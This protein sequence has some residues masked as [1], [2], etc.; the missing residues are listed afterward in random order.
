MWGGPRFLRTQC[1]SGFWFGLKRRG[2]P[3]ANPGERRCCF[4]RGGRLNGRLPTI[5]G[6][7]EFIP[8]VKNVIDLFP[9]EDSRIGLRM[10]FPLRVATIRREC[11][12]MGRP[13]EITSFLSFRRRS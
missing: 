3:V 11:N 6:A 4:S 13:I 7:T 10:R 9:G 5:S 12:R 1:A 8:A 2:A